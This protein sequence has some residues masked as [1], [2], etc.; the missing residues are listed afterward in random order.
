MSQE[1]ID[2]AIRNAVNGVYNAS[3]DEYIKIYNASHNLKTLG[4]YW[5]KNEGG[6]ILMVEGIEI[7][8][9]E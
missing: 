1:L 9:A 5:V 4:V 6:A 7:R 3:K 8:M 2:K